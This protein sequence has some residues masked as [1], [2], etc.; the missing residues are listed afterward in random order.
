MDDHHAVIGLV[1]DG[2]GAGVAG[3]EAPVGV[4]GGGEGVRGQGAGEQ[5]HGAGHAVGV[6][7][8]NGLGLG[9]LHI[10]APTAGLPPGWGPRRPAP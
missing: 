7:R 5:A 9:R 1:D 6:G 10:P 3:E 2:L 4:G 8:S